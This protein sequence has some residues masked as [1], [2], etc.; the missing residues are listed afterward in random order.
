MTIRELINELQEYDENIEIVFNPENSDYV[1][2]PRSIQKK[3]VRAF[4]GKDYKAI[5]IKGEQ[6]GM[7]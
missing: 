6:V 3:E 1:D 2:S 4:W 7:V 5:V